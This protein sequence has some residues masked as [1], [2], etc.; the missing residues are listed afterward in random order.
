[1]GEDKSCILD[2]L[3]T[4]PV[5]LPPSAMPLGMFFHTSKPQTPHLQNGKKVIKY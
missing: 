1:M 4:V 5:V 3:G 2:P